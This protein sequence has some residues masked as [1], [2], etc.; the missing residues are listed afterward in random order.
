MGAVDMAAAAAEADE[1][2][3]FVELGI[4]R[5]VGVDKQRGGLLFGQVSAGVG[6]GREHEQLSRLSH[7]V[8]SRSVHR[9]SCPSVAASIRRGPRPVSLLTSG[10]VGQYTAAKRS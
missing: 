9:G 7:G 8:N 6:A 3:L 4:H 1:G 5:C 2:Q 10:A